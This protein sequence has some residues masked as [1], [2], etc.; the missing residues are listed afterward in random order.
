LKGRASVG[1][2]SGR[3]FIALLKDAKYLNMV[4]K[5]YKGIINFDK[6]YY[7]PIIGFNGIVQVKGCNF[8]GDISVR[9]DNYDENYYF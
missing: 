9:T 7:H 1:V 5:S 6:Y 8:T 2:N 4:D 3:I